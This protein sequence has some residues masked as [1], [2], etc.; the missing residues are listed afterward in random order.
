ML[1]LTFKK[2][3]PLVNSGCCV[4]EYPQPAEKTSDASPFSYCLPVGGVLYFS[5][6]ITADWR[7][8][9]IRDSSCL[10]LGQ[11]LEGFAKM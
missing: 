8:T 3:P 9:Q 10:L 4:E 6:S 5:Q 1:Q 2:L 7:E 11:T